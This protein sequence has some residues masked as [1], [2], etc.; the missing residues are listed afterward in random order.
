MSFAQSVS[1]LKSM[2][3]LAKTDLSNLSINRKTNERLEPEVGFKLTFEPSGT[4][5]TADGKNGKK[6]NSEHQVPQLNVLLIGARHLP[7]SFGLKSVE[8]Y[9]IKVSTS[10]LSYWRNSCQTFR[11]CR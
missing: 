1:K 6:T 2:L 5:S 8:G 3:P 9:M 7:T 10:F 11:L 4:P